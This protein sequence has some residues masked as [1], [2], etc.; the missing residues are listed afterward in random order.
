M[1]MASILAERGE[2]AV[3]DLLASEGKADAS[4][5]GMEGLAL[6]LRDTL[7]ASGYGNGGHLGECI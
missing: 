6:E 1:A 3:E 7:E 5:T 4:I 2:G